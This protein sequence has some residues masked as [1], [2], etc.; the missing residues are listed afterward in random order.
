M[1]G[2]GLV[3]TRRLSNDWRAVR[4]SVPPLFLLSGG[5]Y[6][7]QG[8]GR[9]EQRVSA[10]LARGSW[11]GLVPCA[12]PSQTDPSWDSA[13]PRAG[14]RMPAVPFAVAIWPGV[15]SAS[16]RARQHPLALALLPLAFFLPSLWF[17]I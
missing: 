9:A 10:R 14:G 2:Y 4:E 11:F 12:A 5:R 1:A 13:S 16:P 3:E 8:S 7:Q 6:P 15:P 17:R